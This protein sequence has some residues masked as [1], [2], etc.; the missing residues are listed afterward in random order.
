MPSLQFEAGIEK[1]VKW[2]IDNQEWLNDIIS[3]KYWS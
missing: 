2:Y 3:G 1:T